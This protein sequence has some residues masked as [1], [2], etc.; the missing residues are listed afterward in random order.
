MN[1]DIVAEL[2]AIGFVW[3]GFEGI[4][5]EAWEENLEALR[6]YKSI[7][8]NLN[9]PTTFKLKMGDVEWPEK[10]WDKKLGY[11]VG[12]LRKQEEIMDPARREILDSMG[13]IWDAVQA[14]W[15][16]KLLA[17]ETYKAIHE[18][19]LVKTTFVVPDQDPAWP[20]ATWNMKLGYLVAS[21]RK[22][23]DSLPP[24]I[25]DALITM[26]FVWNFTD[27]RTGPGQ[28]PRFSIAKQ[29]QILEIVQAQYKLQGHTKFTTLPNPFKVPS[30]SEWPQRLHE[31][32]VNVSRFRRAYRLGLL[33]ASIV[34]TLDE[35]RFV[36]DDSQHQWRLLMKALEIFKKIYG[37]VN[38]HQGFEVPEEDP[39]WPNY[40]WGMKLGTRVGTIRFGHTKLTLEKR[41]ELE[42]MNFIW[43][44]N[45][46]HR[47]VILLALKTYKEIYENLSVPSKFVVPSDAPEWPPELAGM[48][49]GAV[50]H[51]L[52][53]RRATMSDELKKRLEEFGFEWI[54]KS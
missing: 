11:S 37:H 5:M 49:L 2:D 26:G 31:C 16:K 13:F 44:A 19:L 39:E 47:N 43:D 4:S 21:C 45:E 33:D 40:L 32:F 41:Q 34:A 1:S 27:K 48:K 50:Y 38:V 6:I 35:M 15:E 18:D 29:N 24:K 9:V 42:K 17:L 20:K 10:L 28:P 25:R 54:D 14:N 23:K 52:R 3:N 30:S 53:A 36:W 12:T 7:H 8:G 51:H 22:T 46:L